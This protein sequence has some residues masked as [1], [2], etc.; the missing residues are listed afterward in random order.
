[1]FVNLDWS[2]KFSAFEDLLSPTVW[3]AK[4]QE[5]ASNSNAKVAAHGIELFQNIFNYPSSSVAQLVRARNK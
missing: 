5:S 3:S 4:P 2:L 1:M